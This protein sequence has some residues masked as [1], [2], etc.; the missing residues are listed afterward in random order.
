[1]SEQGTQPA[2]TDELDALMASI[3]RRVMSYN[4]AFD[5]Q[6]LWS[7]YR[8]AREA[9][10]GQQRKSGEPFVLHGLRVAEIL[11]N[12]RLDVD[13]IVAGLVHDVVEDSAIPLVRLARDF[14]R[15][16]AEMVDGVTKI[17]ELR[18][19]N[20]AT[21]QAENYRKL[22]LHIAQDPRTVL[23]KLADRLHNMRTIEYLPADRQ[24]QVAQE[25]LDVYAPLAHRFGIARIKWELEDLSFK[26]LQPE[27][28]FAIESG[29]H[30]TRAERERLIEEVRQPL[31]RAFAE[32]GLEATITGRPKHFY[33]IYRKMQQRDVG[34]DRIYDLLALRI[35][36][37]SK[38]DCYH[39]L[40]IV[41]NLFPPLRDRIKDFIAAPKPNLYQSIHTTV[42][43][44][45]NRYV[46]LQIRTHEMHE[47]SELGIAA[48]WRYKEG[49]QDQTDFST[50]HRWLRQVMA[51][52][53]DVTDAREFMETLR[54]DFF[55]DEVFVFSPRGDLFQLPAGAT[56]LDFAFRIHSEVGLHCVGAKVNGRIVSLRTALQNRDEVEIL[57]AKTATPSTSWLG[58]VKTGRAKHHIRRWIKATQF[59]ESVK[60]GRDIIDRELARHKIRLAAD[61]ELVDIAQE[62]GYSELDKLL[63]AVGSGDLP[64]QRVLNHI[65]PPS[66]SPAGKV[67][68][69]GRELYDSLLRRQASGVQVAGIDNLMVHFARCCQPIPGD[70]IV[71]LV[72][73]GRGVSVHRVGCPNLADPQFAD[74]RIEVGWDSRPDQVF[75]VKIIVTAS[76]RKSLLA[77]LGKVISETSTNIRSG[78]FSSENDLARA[79]L[80]V[81]VRNLNNLQKIL[82]AIRKV[83]GVHRVERYQLG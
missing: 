79:T 22:V 34:L 20:P 33:S 43:V 39:A 31:V 8:F 5:Q 16:V 74:R 11:A 32:A 21:R 82:K 19:A 60:L 15:D 75:V 65:Q 71:G 67:V 81:E 55:Q 57:T 25:T 27:R 83:P 61:R 3:V 48:H 46:E 37:A 17:S 80:L 45:G 1:M 63:A 36:V 41:H 7:A 68:E 64:Y 40:G 44:D 28:Y 59:Q 77:D 9:H 38:A 66:R 42:M 18:D 73:R 26:V 51:W 69:M 78:E 29:I 52:Q 2:Q 70:E 10:R 47:N 54:I 6:K 13:T 24:Q 4:P 62:M 50:I 72:T 23:I 56:P 76:D 14:G 35:I 49:S 30:E 58:I 12:L 53:Q